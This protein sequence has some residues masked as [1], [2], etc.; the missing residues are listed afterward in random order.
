MVDISAAHPKHKT[1]PLGQELVQKRHSTTA[2]CWGVP[3]V[4]WDLAGQVEH[5]GPLLQIA[6][7]PALTEWSVYF[8]KTAVTCFVAFISLL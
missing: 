3:A 5:Q 7:F 2:S 1:A 6:L 8:V 4:L